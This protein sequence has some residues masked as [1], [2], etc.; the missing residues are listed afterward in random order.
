M[1]LSLPEYSA[2]RTLAGLGCGYTPSGDDVLA[3][4]TVAVAAYLM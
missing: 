1:A 3:G 4:Y 2:T